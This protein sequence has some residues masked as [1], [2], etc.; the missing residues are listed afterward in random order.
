MAKVES[1]QVYFVNGFKF[2]TKNYSEK[3]ATVNYGVCIYGTNYTESSYDYYGI[4]EEIIILEYPRLP[5]KKVALFKCD[6]YDPTPNIGTRVHKKYNFVDVN[7]TKRLNKYEPFILAGQAAQ[8]CF[9][10]YPYTRNRYHK[11]Y[12]PTEWLAVC[13]VKA[14]SFV[15]MPLSTPETPEEAPAFQ[16]DEPSGNPIPNE[17]DDIIPETLNDPSGTLVEVFDGDT[18]SEDE[19]LVDSSDSEEEFYDEPED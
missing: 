6:W 16:E 11:K 12:N 3:K 9:V 17:D 15:Q 4:L 1:Y 10:P 14:R 5:I 7:Q 8:V 13:K 18:D 19:V 2:H